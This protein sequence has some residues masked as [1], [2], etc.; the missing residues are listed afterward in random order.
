MAD[1][2]DYG[3]D[4]IGTAHTAAL[5]GGLS[6]EI[7][8][9]AAAT[10]ALI[11]SGR[12]ETQSPWTSAQEVG[13]AAQWGGMAGGAAGGALGF[14]GCVAGEWSIEQLHE[15]NNYINPPP[16]TTSPPAT[17]DGSAWNAPTFTEPTHVDAPASDT[18][19]Q[20]PAGVLNWADTS[21]TVGPTTVVEVVPPAPS[22]FE[23]VHSVFD[24][25][26][27]SGSGDHSGSWGSSDT[28]SSSHDNGSSIHDG[29]TGM[30][31]SGSS[32]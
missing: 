9:G 14:G 4:C 6:G 18:W 2:P 26:P 30:G 17:G 23:S 8:A 19:S 1:E 27:S 11:E 10:G 5:A 22:I 3:A 7:V 29:G 21:P 24:A 32:V 28:G 25:T 12:A 15:L 20:G 16:D 13:T 31:D